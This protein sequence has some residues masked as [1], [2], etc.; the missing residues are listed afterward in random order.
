MLAERSP[1]RGI[2]REWRYSISI[3]PPFDPIHFRK[4]CGQFATGVTVV[5]TRHE[6]HIHGMTASSFISVSLDALR[7]EEP[8]S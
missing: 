6:G 1:S 3:A 2:I 5:T 7:G 8:K 4:T